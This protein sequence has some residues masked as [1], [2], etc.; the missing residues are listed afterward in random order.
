MPTTVPPGSALAVKLYS[1]ALFA[2][3]QRAATFKNYM[4]GP[5]PKQ[6]DAESKLR[7]QSS[8]DYPFVRCNDLAKGGGEK[9][10]IDL[11]NIIKGKPVMGDKKLTGRLMP[12]KSSSMDITINQ[13][14][15]GVDPGGRM[16]QQRTIHNLRTVAKS[17]IVG[18]NGRLEDQVSLVHVAGSRGHQDDEEW[19]VPLST[20][21]EF[22][23]IMVNTVLAPSYGRRMIAGGGNS[24]TDLSTSDF[25]T[26]GDI[27]RIRANVDEMP[28][29]LQPIKL[30]GDPAADDQPLYCMWVTSRQW[31]YIQVNATGQQWRQFMADAMTRAAG[32]P[33]MAKHPLFSGNPG[34]WNGIL[35]KKS[36]RAI[37]FT[38]NVAAAEQN[39]S[40]AEVNTTVA[41]AT[42][43]AI[44]LGAQ[45]LGWAYGKHGGSG[46]HYSW[47]EEVTDHGNVVEISTACMSGAAKVRFTGSNGL[48][49]DHGVLVID[50]Y[51]PVVS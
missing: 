36:R 6:P 14:R 20:D 44:M 50:S 32:I 46:Y 10:S 19:V 23:E 33:G 22:A 43:R 38:A 48:T 3:T 49:E 30:S 35:I 13:C 37:R 31:H 9:V 12:L 11:F 41:V 8:Q 21:A 28:F 1:V 7:G 51:A 24:Y 34:M 17:N 42:D 18:W 16:S 27:D 45:A 26:L 29:P 15:G 39:S 4:T 2:E 47:H 40:Y 5:M 25:L